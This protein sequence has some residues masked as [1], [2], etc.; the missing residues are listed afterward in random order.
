[1]RRV[2]LLVAVLSACSKAPEQKLPAPQPAAQPDTETTYQRQVRAI[3][4]EAAAMDTL[5]QAAR[6]TPAYAARFDSLRK[7][8][9][10]LVR[11]AASR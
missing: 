5:P 1:M 9:R 8:E 6:F 10:E 7:V 4:A 11:P 2:V 3:N